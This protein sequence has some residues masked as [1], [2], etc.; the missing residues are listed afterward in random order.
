MAKQEGQFSSQAIRETLKF[1]VISI[2]FALM[3]SV[4][5]TSRDEPAPT[6]TD[7]YWDLLDDI[8]DN[9]GIIG[10][11][12]R[13]I[14]PTPVSTPYPDMYAWAYT[15]ATRAV[16][17]ARPTQDQ[18]YPGNYP[19]AYICEARNLNKE[20]PD[21]D[22]GDPNLGIDFSELDDCFTDTAG[23]T[24]TLGSGVAVSIPVIL[25]IPPLWVSQAGSGDSGDPY[26]KSYLPDWLATPSAATFKSSGSN[27]HYV[28]YEYDELQT[29][30]V[31]FIEKAGAHFDADASM[32]NRLAAVRIRVGVDGESSP[33]YGVSPDTTTSMLQQ[34]E[35]SYSTC[36]QYIAFINALKGAARSAFP[37]KPVVVMSTLKPGYSCSP[38]QAEG[39]S[40][41]R[42]NIVETAVASGK[43]IGLSN[44][45]LKSSS[46][47]FDSY[48]GM[49]YED[50]RTLVSLK[51]ADEN[52]LPALA[53]F[54]DS[55]GVSSSWVGS[56]S[57]DWREW[58][59][60][61]LM[62]YGAQ[63]DWIAYNSTWSGYMSIWGMWFADCI[64]NPRCAA[65]VFHDL[66][67]PGWG[68]DD[69]NYGYGDLRGDLARNVTLANATRYPQSCRPAL[70]TAARATATAI[71][72]GGSLAYTPLPCWGDALPTPK[73]TLISLPTPNETVQPRPT[74]EP[75]AD[76]NMLQR[77][78]DR[79]ARYIGASGA[80]TLTLNS[81]WAYA[82]D[83]YE[84]STL[85]V[86]YLDSN[87]ADFTVAW[88]TGPSATATRVIDRKGD[89]I[90]KLEQWKGDL[91]TDG[92]IIITN[93]AAQTWLHMVGFVLSGSDA[94][95]TATPTPAP[96]ATPSY[97]PISC[98]TLAVTVDGELSEWS[99]VTPV[100]L[101]ADTSS[102]LKTAPTVT[103]TPAAANING[104][105][106]CAWSGS[107]LY[108]AGTITDATVLEPAGSYRNGDSALVAVDGKGDGF[109][110]LRADD[111][112]FYIP[113]P[114]SGETKSAYVLD[115]DL[116]PVAVTAIIK[117]TA[118]GWQFEM[119][120]PNSVHQ[121][122]TLTD[123]FM[124]LQY[125]LYDRDA[126]TRFMYHLMSNHRRG[127]FD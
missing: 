22:A 48:A 54:G 123:K 77:L 83:T 64:S 63:A 4:G 124:G 9:G 19:I 73:A 47:D 16:P 85:R 2:F 56:N 59:W 52:N 112:D 26:N 44:H 84:D 103:A 49:T 1:C 75:T 72:A 18:G 101:S 117:D 104:A 45:N 107:T 23:Y 20:W 58:Y 41:L 102:Y 81:E 116:Y 111:H 8:Y 39:G 46:T 61:T 30:L 91:Y 55:K 5:C 125:G 62:G 114:A 89:G 109:S 27:N 50:W 95:P 82:E 6:P 98:P 17:M 87:S 31:K 60:A 106:Y 35:A 80:M 67:Q 88:P 29:Y 76:L 108:V 71:K 127:E 12:I 120:V 119:S 7:D 25:N 37:G 92:N 121:G 113:A 100:A 68:W 78:A 15:I 99:A 10:G 79:Q 38:S 14:N 90:W 93:G 36:A 34:H 65:V 74:F 70:A 96:T 28:G 110:R 118:N 66:E 40:T 11:G 69:P 86:I 122:G 115:Y 97:A 105:F 57:D 53:E 43:P 42:K 51:T 13:A 21:Y 33:I 3:I 32:Y 126:G 94:E 24:V